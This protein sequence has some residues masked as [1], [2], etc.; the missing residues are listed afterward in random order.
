MK[1]ILVI[2]T[3]NCEPQI[4]RLLKKS[5]KT[6]NAQF[7]EIV[8]IDNGSTDKTIDNA[9]NEMKLIDIQVKVLQ[10]KKNISLGGS[11]K[12]G[13]LYAE[14]N[15]YDLIAILHGDDQANLDDLLPMIEKMKIE[16]IDLAIGARFHSK[17]ELIGYSAFRK[18]G[19]RL[20][21]IYCILCTGA[22]IDDL[23]AGLNLYRVSELNLN[24]VL[25]YPDNLTFDVHILLRAIDLK[26][27]IEF[28]PISWKEEDQIS[29]A[30]VVKQAIVIL[31]LFTT[32][33]FKREHALKF[34]KTQNTYRDYRV[35][36]ERQ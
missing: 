8:I 27:S 1:S 33:F 25:N 14:E 28:F 16:K 35:V 29:N 3:Y 5:S 4:G 2:P 36:F 24:E 26:Q 21:N 18:I 22:K 10:N 11:L 19:N 6:I 7:D 31:R 15:Q 13:F 20:L 30:K 23:I 34:Q 12:T 32:Y 9:I 17:S